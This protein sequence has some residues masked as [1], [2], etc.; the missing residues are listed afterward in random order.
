MAGIDGI[1]NKIHP[2]EP[3]DKNIYDLK[4]E[5][6]AE[7]KSTCGSLD[8]AL[9]EFERDHEYLMKGD[10]FTEDVIRTWIDYKTEQEVDAV[11]VRPHPYEFVMYF[12]I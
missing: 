5:E 2:G 3:L 6:L 4:P 10:V 7:V 9:Q 11:R 8:E 12:D 1:T